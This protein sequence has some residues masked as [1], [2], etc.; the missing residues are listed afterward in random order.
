MGEFMLELYV[1][2]NERDAV[3]ARAQ[4]ARTCAGQVRRE[5]AAVRLSLVIFV[6]EDETCLLV[7]E[8]ASVESVRRCAHLAGLPVE[9]IVEA[10]VVEPE[11]AD[12][13]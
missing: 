8:A 4:R 11:M 9:H 7:Y 12:V 2:R 5:G 6:P 13:G 10:I 1:S 3:L